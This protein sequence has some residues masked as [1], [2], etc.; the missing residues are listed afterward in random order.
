[1]VDGELAGRYSFRVDPADL[2]PL[3]DILAIRDP[4]GDL[5][6]VTN[7]LLGVTWVEAVAVALTGVALALDGVLILEQEALVFL[8]DKAFVSLN[9]RE[10]DEASVVVVPPPFSGDLLATGEDVLR[11]DVGLFTLTRVLVRRDITVITTLTWGRH[12]H[13][14]VGE[15]RRSRQDGDHKRVGQDHDNSVNGDGG[16]GLIDW[17]EL[18]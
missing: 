5:D 9:K 3:E 15:G 18:E 14:R 6:R 10:L 4:V 11:R 2:G 16:E 1:M 13:V 8:S 17:L 7:T 12:E